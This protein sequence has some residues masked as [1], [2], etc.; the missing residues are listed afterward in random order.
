MSKGDDF[1][2]CANEFMI[3]PRWKMRGFSQYQIPEC[4]VGDTRGRS[5]YL[6]WQWSAS[7]MQ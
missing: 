2:G 5:Q 4:P 6:G 3:E 7:I 1:Y